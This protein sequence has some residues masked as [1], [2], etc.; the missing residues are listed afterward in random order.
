MAVTEPFGHAYPG[1]HGPLQLLAVS[2]VVDP[3]QGM[4]SLGKGH[5]WLASHKNL[6][7][8]C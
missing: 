8:G 5:R 1:V 7:E 6:Q 2:A 4:L 3:K